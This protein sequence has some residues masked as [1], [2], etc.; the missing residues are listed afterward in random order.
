MLRRDWLGYTEVL[1]AHPALEMEYVGSCHSC[2]SAEMFSLCKWKRVSQGS[3]S[4]V[5]SGGFGASSTPSSSCEQSKCALPSFPDPCQTLLTV[6]MDDFKDWLEHFP[7][8]GQTKATSPAFKSVRSGRYNQC[9][10]T[11]MLE[12]IW[13]FF[14]SSGGEG[15]SCPT[16][17]KLCI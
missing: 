14:Q 6:Q 8:L 11:T 9:N 4:A 10:G 13:G 3:L 17:Y 16:T 7:F 12:V 1:P 15:G 5:L 2:F